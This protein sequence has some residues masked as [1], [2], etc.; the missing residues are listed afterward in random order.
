V[1]RLEYPE[2]LAAIRRESARFREVLTTCD[3][4]ARVP[5]CPDWTA[6][7]LLW[8]LTTVQHWWHA[9]ITNRPQSAEE[10]GY[11]EP[12][13]PEGYD[14]LLA[15]YDDTH[16]AF[17]T[18]LAAADPAE[19]AH[20][21]SG[22]PANHTVG[23]TYR[24]QAHE[25]LIH[26][27]DAE[28]TA[29]TVTPLDRELAADGVDEAL[30]WMYGDLPPWGSFDPLPRFVEFRMSDAG[31]S[32]WTQLGIFAGTSPGGDVYADEKDLHV[33]PAPGRPAEVV[34]EGDA[35]AL[36]AWLWK[37]RDDAGITVTG[38]REVYDFARAVL[39]QP[40]D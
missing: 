12:E 6:A 31:T 25:A 32:V 26:R 37:R 34:V 27:L 24:R 39:D 29:G 18:G 20:S 1:T 10:M 4:A 15:A 13:R 8:H 35:A 7:D 11:T 16:T 28:L 9:M 38:D 2:Y 19:P 3:P 23:F 33:V 14:S 30:D 21:W 40:I 36:D 17:V 22:D 5:S